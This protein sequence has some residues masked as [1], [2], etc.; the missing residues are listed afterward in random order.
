MTLQQQ[1]VRPTDQWQ[2]CPWSIDKRVVGCGKSFREF[3]SFSTRILTA[4]LQTFVCS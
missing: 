4:V 2:L 1:A 3:L